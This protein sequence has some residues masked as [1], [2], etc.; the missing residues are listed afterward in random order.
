MRERAQAIL[1]DKDSELDKLRQQLRDRGVTGALQHTA[2]GL[3]SSAFGGP[4]SRSAAHSR[5]PSASSFLGLSGSGNTLSS[6]AA[7]GGGHLWSSPMGLGRTGSGV[8]VGGG[9]SSGSGGAGS[10]VAGRAGS[11]LAREHSLQQSRPGSGGGLSH[12]GTASGVLPLSTFRLSSD[13][14]ELGVGMGS[15]TAVGA[16]APVRHRLAELEAQVRACKL[17]P[18]ECDLAISF[19]VPLSSG[20]KVVAG[21]V[22]AD[23]R[24]AVCKRID[25][26]GD[27][28]D[29]R[30]RMRQPSM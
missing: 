10:P 19:R 7:G 25:G 11:S 21:T 20:M 27:G 23:G 29:E 30:D 15:P 12:A 24:S 22:A 18:R 28:G 9:V 14:A 17:L 6:A 3:S 13:G 16:S 8:H 4:G 2:G 5:T 1:E 26:W